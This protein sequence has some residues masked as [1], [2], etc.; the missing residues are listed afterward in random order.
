MLIKN[1][2]N[3]LILI[4]RGFIPPFFGEIM[5]KVIVFLILTLFNL[6]LLNIKDLI[7]LDVYFIICL[8]SLDILLC[9][10]IRWILKQKEINKE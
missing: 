9:V 6:F 4:F 2:L 10:F 8:F 5:N 1:I 3:F 7:T